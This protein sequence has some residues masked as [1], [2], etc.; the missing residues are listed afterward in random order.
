MI[1]KFGRDLTQHPVGDVDVWVDAQ[2]KRGKRKAS[3][4]YGVGCSD[5]NFVITG[6]S[7]SG[8]APTFAEY[9]QSQRRVCFHC[10]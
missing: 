8:N 2:R 5:P 10:H 6:T 3:R 1:E 4:I 9:E 7:S